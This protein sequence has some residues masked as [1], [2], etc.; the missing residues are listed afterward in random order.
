MIPKVIYDIIIKYCNICILCKKVTFD[1]ESPSPVYNPDDVACNKC[2]Y[3]SGSIM[4]CI[5]YYNNLKI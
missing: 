5:K 3:G 1:F 2:L 4:K